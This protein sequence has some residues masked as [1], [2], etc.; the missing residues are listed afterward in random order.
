MERESV[1][2]DINSQQSFEALPL[3]SNGQRKTWVRM[4][5]SHLIQ[6]SPG[7]NRLVEFVGRAF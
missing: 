3:K 6:Q 4:T 5:E 2:H 1:S 7:M